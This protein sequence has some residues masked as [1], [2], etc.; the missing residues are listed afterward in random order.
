MSISIFYILGYITKIE[1]GLIKISNGA[2]IVAKGVKMNGLHILDG[3]IVIAHAFVASQT[4]QDKTQL[5]L[6]R[7]GHVSERGLV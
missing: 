7:L 3:S 4:L 1:R 2:L 6:L 5:W